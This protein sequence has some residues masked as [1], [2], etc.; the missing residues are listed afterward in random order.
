[1]YKVVS[2]VVYKRCVEG[3]D[4]VETTVEARFSMGLKNVCSC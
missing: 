2:M 1:M 3:F 4:S